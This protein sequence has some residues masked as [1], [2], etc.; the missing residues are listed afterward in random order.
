MVDQL[1]D[2]NGGPLPHHKKVH[3]HSSILIPNSMLLPHSRASSLGQTRIIR[4]AYEQEYTH[5]MEECYQYTE[6]GSHRDPGPR[7]VQPERGTRFPQRPWAQRSSARERNQV[8]TE[9]LGQ[10]E[11]SQRLPQVNLLAGEGALIDTQLG[12]FPISLHLSHAFPETV[13]ESGGSVKDGDKVAKVQPGS[14]LTVTTASGANT[15]VAHTGLQ[16]PLQLGLLNLSAPGTYG[17]SHFPC[18]VQMGAEGAHYH[19]Y[20]LLSN[21][22]PGLMKVRNTERVRQTDRTNI[23]LLS[24]FVSLYLSGLEP[25]PA[26]VESCLYTVTPDHHFV[27]D[28]HPHHGNIVI[29]AGFLLGRGKLKTICYWQRGLELSFLLVCYLMYT[30]LISPGRLKLHLTKTG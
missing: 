17:I 8:T 26:L 24:Q 3:V 5:M 20:G 6:P 19:L 9:T 15:L 11:F 10:V 21:E 13:P 16:L 30:L 18:F 1:P 4:K 12:I 2:Q 29:G 27:L 14:S 28:R 22:C 7:G 25:E 23:L